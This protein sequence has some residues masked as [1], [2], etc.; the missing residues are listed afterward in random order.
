LLGL[1]LGARQRW[2]E[3]RGQ[4]GDNGND[5]E[6]LNQRKTAPM[7]TANGFHKTTISV[8]A[9][10]RVTIRTPRPVIVKRTVPGMYLE[11]DNPSG[12]SP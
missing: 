4:N 8:Y 11:A 9:G 12:F 3:Q 6:Q 5:H 1:R 10:E 2:Q 7:G